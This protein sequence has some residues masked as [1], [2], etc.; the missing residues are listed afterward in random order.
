M[1]DK[2]IE[3]EYHTLWDAS[4]SIDR[5]RFIELL[6]QEYIGIKCSSGLVPA[7]PGFYSIDFMTIIH[8]ST[9]IIHL[10]NM[11]DKN[12]ADKRMYF[13]DVHMKLY[14][15]IGTGFLTSSDEVEE[16]ING[17]AMVLENDEM[18]R[19]FYNKIR[20]IIAS[21]SKYIF[22]MEF[23]RKSEKNEKNVLYRLLA[24]YS[25]AK[26]NVARIKYL[27]SLGLGLI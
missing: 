8:C 1:N 18:L 2:D 24:E 14:Q 5:D 23:N 27:Y 22:Q 13:L 21:Y 26:D 9:M 6:Q 4:A 16:W 17:I 25:E 3:Y 15:I 10:I 11:I 7:K 19:T 12:D 20:D